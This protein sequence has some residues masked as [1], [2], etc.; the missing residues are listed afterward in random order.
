VVQLVNIFSELD[1]GTQEIFDVLTYSS[2]DDEQKPRSW[3]LLSHCHLHSIL[4][5]KTTK[6]FILPIG[7]KYKTG[8]SLTSSFWSLKIV[9]GT[10]SETINIHL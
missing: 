5:T 10:R 3:T 8:T 2:L 1:L 9:I 7:R 4:S 6:L